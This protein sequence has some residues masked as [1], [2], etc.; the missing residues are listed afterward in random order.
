M[1]DYNRSTLAT[2]VISMIRSL[3]VH[4][5]VGRDCMN[6][7]ADLS[8]FWVLIPYGNWIPLVDFSTSF[9]QGQQVL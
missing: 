1:I 5:I 3:A 4:R 8:L 9:P 7:K 2:V 6:M